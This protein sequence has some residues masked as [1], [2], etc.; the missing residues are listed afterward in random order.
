MLMKLRFGK[1]GWIELDQMPLESHVVEGVR[2]FEPASAEAGRAAFLT[3]AVVAQTF[4]KSV[5]SFATPAERERIG[6]DKVETAAFRDK[7]GAIRVVY[8]EAVVRFEPQRTQAQRKAV[9][10]KFHLKVRARNTFHRDQVIVYDPKRTYVAQRMIE[11]ANELTET[12]EIAFAFP[13][14]VSEFKRTAAPTPRAEQWHL[15]VVEARRAWATTLGK[16]ITVAVLDDGVDVD[17]PNLKGNIRRNP[18][19]G[20][21]RDLCGRDFFVGEDAAEHFNPRPKLFR[22]PFGQMA[23]NDI[24]GTCCAGVAAAA[25][26]LAK[27]F[28]AAPKAQLLPVKVF[29]AD[30]LAT[31]SRVADAI[32]YASRFADILSCS[33]KGPESPDIEAA[34]EEAGGGRGGKG[35]PV[36]VAT[37][38]DHAGVV[39]YPARSPHAIAVGAS[40]NKEKRA[41]YSNFGPEVSIVASSNGGTAGIFTTDVGYPDR[42]FNLGSAA[43]GG[44]DGLHANDFGGTSSATPLAAGVAALVLS[45]NPNLPR[46]DVRKI[47]QE[48]ADK[49]GPANAYKPNGHSDEYGYGRINADKAVARALQLAAA[50]P[51]ARTPARAT[52][53]PRA[54]NARRTRRA[55]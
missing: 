5:R 34:L 53:R 8:R 49:I 4:E 31:E 12:A 25:G 3:N 2:V 51:G 45:A 50:T 48:T 9:L 11:L 29:H 24:H 13:N 40:T 22:A 6:A 47:L 35:C 20:E 54:R 15:R 17:H 44:A 14:F 36:F 23:G 42:G 26:A 1:Q 46:G 30:A 39:A 19:P 41:A 7:S 55:A 27:V 16:G 32:R 28:G 10:D 37:G 38:N 21:P 33:W 43:A 52:G 18:D